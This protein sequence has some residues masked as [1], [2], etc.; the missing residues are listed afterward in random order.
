MS[1]SGI[2]AAQEDAVSCNIT[3]VTRDRGSLAPVCVRVHVCA[4]VEMSAAPS[5]SSHVI[6]VALRV[7][8]CVRV[9]VR[10]RVCACV[11]IILI[12]I[13]S[14]TRGCRAWHQSQNTVQTYLWLRVYECVYF[15]WF[16]ILFLSVRA[17]VWCVR[18]SLSSENMV[19]K[20]CWSNKS[21]RTQTTT[22]QSPRKCSI[23]DQYPCVHTES[24]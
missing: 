13:L 11:S 21:P 2:G 10:V 12:L 3:K 19:S 9:R 18:H 23:T 20:V 15:S 4:H 22:N 24:K 8:V 14:C 16:P 1:S 7:R 6:G 17:C 5:T